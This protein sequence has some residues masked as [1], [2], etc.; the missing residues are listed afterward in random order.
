MEYYGL[1][2]ES[3]ILL[4]N[5]ASALGSPT[6]LTRLADFASSVIR[7]ASLLEETD[8]DLSWVMLKQNGEIE[9]LEGETVLLKSP[10]GVSFELKV[11]DGL[12]TPNANFSVKCNDGV[13]YVTTQRVSHLPGESR[14]M[15]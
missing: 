7:R 4:A 1:A 8:N 9:P 5:S 2:P 12:Q 11:A 15:P 3:S 14:A 6:G 13:A 10:D